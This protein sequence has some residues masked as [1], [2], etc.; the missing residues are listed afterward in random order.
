MP[1]LKGVV[2]HDGFCE[3]RLGLGGLGSRRRARPRQGGDLQCPHGPA[4]SSRASSAST[5]TARVYSFAMRGEH[6]ELLGVVSLAGAPL[7]RAHRGTSAAPTCVSWCSPRSS[8]CAAS[9]RCA[10]SSARASGISEV[11]ERD[12][13]LMLEMSSNQSATGDADEFDLILKTALEHMGC[14]L[15]ALWVPDKNIGLSMTRSGNPDVAGVAAARATAS[16]G[17][18]AAAAAHH[19]RQ[20]H[21]QSGERRG[22]SLQDSGVPGAPPIRARDGSA[23]AFQSGERTR[24]RFPSD[25]RRRAS[26][27]ESDRHHPGAVRCRAPGS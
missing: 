21:L 27:E 22:R 15:A 9:C 26:G 12:L 3:P 18:D 23:G 8:A 25:A 2:V 16:D 17:L 6:V 1:S 7:G 20:S 11:R 4:R 14:A 19:R 13:S 5:R 10:P 24:F